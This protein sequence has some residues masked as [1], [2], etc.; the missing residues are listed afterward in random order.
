MEFDESFLKEISSESYVRK[1]IAVKYIEGKGLGLFTNT[2]IPKGEIVSISGGIVV[3]K[4]FYEDVAKKN[5]YD[6][7]A[8]FIEDDFLIMP[9]NPKNPSPDWRMNHCCDANCGIVGQTTF[10]AMRDIEEG[11]ELTFDY[12]MSESDPDYEFYLNCT[13]SICRKKFSGNDWKN[14]ELQ[15]KYKGYFSLY[16]KRK[17]E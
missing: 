7:Y 8:Y 17:M 3:S 11:E 14:P 12:C 5:G 15:K 10:V 1:G 9:L 16:I 2:K 6:D 4:T 13:K